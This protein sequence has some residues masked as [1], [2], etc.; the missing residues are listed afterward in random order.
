[1]KRIIICCD[2]TWNDPDKKD[3]GRS[4]ASNVAKMAELILPL[5]NEGVD[6]VTYYHEGVGTGDLK[7]RILG[8]A[9]GVGLSKNLEDCYRFLISNF[10]EGDQ[11]WLFG[12]SRGAYTARSLIGLIRNSGLLKKKFLDK[13]PE[14][15]GLYRDRTDATH[16]N[17]ATAKKF[18]TQYAYEEATTPIYF[19]GV[20]DTVGSLGIPDTLISKLFD[21]KWK[22][23]DVKLSG[24]V[25]NAYHALAIDEIRA[26]FKPCL[27]E[28]PDTTKNEQVWF[29]GSH[30]DVGG[31]YAEAGLSDCALAWMV[32]RARTCGLAI[33]ATHVP[34]SPSPTE[35][36][37]PS[38]KGFFNFRPAYERT[39]A[40]PVIASSAFTRNSK[41]NYHPDNWP[42]HPTQ[43][44]CPGGG[45]CRNFFRCH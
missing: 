29:P 20:W 15:F 41:K 35:Y 26:D 45:T 7:D 19:L 22:F 16:P 13:L 23:H 21:D 31:G 24:I 3:K 32:C 17:T 44:D 28:A 14:A 4:C 37:H 39:V 11:I 38:K 9:C 25:E 42:E 43:Q 6:Q 8:G 33:G 12:F 40:P 18:R 27:W 5:S 10:V 34:I 2:G 1:M 36:L 30:S